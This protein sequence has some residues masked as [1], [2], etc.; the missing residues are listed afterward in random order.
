MSSHPEIMPDFLTVEIL[1]SPSYSDPLSSYF[2]P[3]EKEKSLK[4]ISSPQGWSQRRTIHVRT[5]PSERVLG[6]MF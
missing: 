4:K 5:I 1:K 6:N 3:L 2:H